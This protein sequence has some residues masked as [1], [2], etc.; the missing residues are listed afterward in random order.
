M[1]YQVKQSK[2]NF[3][4]ECLAK[5]VGTDIMS[6]TD[7]NQQ[8]ECTPEQPSRADS[9]STPYR[10]HEMWKRKSAFIVF[11]RSARIFQTSRCHLKI[12]GACRMTVS[13]LIGAIPLCYNDIVVFITI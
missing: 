2:K 1:V 7:S 8:T 12:L 13:N 11:Y 4:Y 5:E 3:P 10:K 6:L 9:S